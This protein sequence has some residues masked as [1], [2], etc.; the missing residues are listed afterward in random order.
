MLWTQE[1]D[2]ALELTR[3]A[4]EL[5]L[6][7][8]SNLYFGCIY[9]CFCFWQVLPAEL[10]ATKQTSK[11]AWHE[12]TAKACARDRCTTISHSCRTSEV[13]KIAVSA[14][15]M[16]ESNYKHTCVAKPELR[17]RWMSKV[18]VTRTDVTIGCSHWIPTHYTC[19]N[20]QSI[21]ATRFAKQIPDQLRTSVCEAT[22]LNARCSLVIP[23][24]FCMNPSVFA[25]T[26]IA[27]SIILLHNLSC[28]PGTARST[29]VLTN[30]S[31]HRK[32]T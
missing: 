11:I 31:E 15:D 25:Q 18:E 10:L 3:R 9:N 12:R 16:L 7:L 28:H 1:S 14:L 21:Q 32:A 27:Q 4:R 6:H 26:H 23:T 5:I 13:H 22:H 8:N 24:R 20:V 2:F 19:D 30:T 29:E 17:H